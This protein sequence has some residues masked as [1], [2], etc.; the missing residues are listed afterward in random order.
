MVWEVVSEAT[1]AAVQ[2]HGGYGVATEYDV[3]RFYREAR[4]THI[5]PVSDEMILNYLG[6]HVLDLPRSY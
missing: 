5:A 3:E 6:E 4:L 2:T 1:D